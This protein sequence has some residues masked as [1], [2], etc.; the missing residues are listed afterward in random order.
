VIDIRATEYQ[1]EC[2]LPLS[3]LTCEGTRFL[4]ATNCAGIYSVD[5]DI[6]IVGNVNGCARFHE[7]FNNRAGDRAIAKRIGND[8]PRT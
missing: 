3:I 2:V 8:V 5:I 7:T 1:V 4:L 6:I